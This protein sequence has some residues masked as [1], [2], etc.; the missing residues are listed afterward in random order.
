[1]CK[2]HERHAPPEWGSRTI[3]TNLAT[4]SSARAWASSVER[5]LFRS[6]IASGAFHLDRLF[7]EITSLGREPIA[8]NALEFQKCHIR[9]STQGNLF[10]NLLVQRSAPRLLRFT[11]GCFECLFRPLRLGLTLSQIILFDQPETE[12]WIAVSPARHSINVWR[13]TQIHASNSGDSTTALARSPQTEPANALLR[14]V[15]KS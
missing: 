3:L 7:A 14:L 12:L 10:R 4:A 9:A 11:Q 13:I 15:C 6:Q 2:R 8:Q 1:M 5:S